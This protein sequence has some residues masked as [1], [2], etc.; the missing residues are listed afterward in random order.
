MEQHDLLDPINEK[1]LFALHCV[2][3]PRI[4]RSLKQFKEAWNCHGLRTERGKNPNQLFTAG[5]LRL[6]YSGLDTVNPF[7]DFS[8]EYRESEE[9]GSHNEEAVDDDQGVSV[10]QLSISI[11]PMQ[12]SR[13][14]EAVSPLSDNREY[15]ISLNRIVLQTL[16][17]P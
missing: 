15:G 2:Y 14:H 13:I 5:L 6:R 12:L 1:H 9:G 10:P 4:N 8:D 11:V 3:L 17:N 16:D 7:E